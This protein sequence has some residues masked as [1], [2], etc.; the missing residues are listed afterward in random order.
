MT[1]V[2]YSH[3]FVVGVDTHA[4]KHVFAIIAASGERIESRDFPA[5]GAGINRAIAWVAR[6]TEADLA[7]LWVIEGAASYGAVLAGAVAAAGYQV[8]EATRMDALPRRGVGKSDPLDAHRIASAVLSLEEDKLRRPRLNEGVRAAL[9]VLVTARYSMTTDRTRTVNALTALLRINDLGFDARKSLSGRQILE[10]SRW[11]VR[12]EA[13]A[14]SVARSEAV[15]LAKRIGDLDAEI[16]AN[17]SRITELVEVSEAAPL[18]QESGFGPVTAAICL[19]AWSHQGR[20]RSEAAF[21][22]LAGV[23]NPIPASSGNTVRHR[24]NRGGDRT[25][26]KALHMVALTRM[27]FDPAT[28]EYVAKRQAEGR[29]KKEIRRCVKRYLARRIYRTLNANSP[30]PLLR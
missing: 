4:R 2:A 29:T 9:R 1:I 5:T 11:R 28:I 21:A 8:A 30:Q 13:L 19:T 14:E 23:I 10:V 18:L 27:A 20:V 26:N 15:R 12:E 3:P 25:L 22:S 17:G 24:L 6:R 16:K 7:T